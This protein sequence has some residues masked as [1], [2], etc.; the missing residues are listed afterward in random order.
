MSSRKDREQSG[1]T[2]TG[3]FLARTAVKDGRLGV[4]LHIARNLS[5]SLGEREL[6]GI[7]M[8]GLSELIGA[9]RSTLY[10]VS[11]DGKT[12]RSVV[13]EGSQ[14]IELP[15]GE[16]IAGWVAER[17]REL[18]LR[19]VYEDPRF[20]PTWDRLHG[21]RTTSML[22]Q[23]VRQSDGKIIAVAQAINKSS[24]YFTVDDQQMM[25]HIMAMAAISIVNSKL[26][27]SLTHRNLQLQQANQ[28]LDEYI[29]EIQMLFAIERDAMVRD[30]IEGVSELV[31][32]EL[33]RA[34]PC[35]V[36]QISLLHGK[37]VQCFRLSGEPDATMQRLRRP[38]VDGYLRLVLRDRAGLHPICRPQLERHD[39]L[40]AEE[41]FAFV[42]D[43]GLT[44]AM[45]T[46]DGEMLGAIGLYGRHAL[47]ACF[48]PQDQQMISLVGGNVARILQR[49]RAREQQEQQGRL[50]SLGSALSM[51]LHDFK[52]P[53]TI[54]SGYVQMMAKHPDP[55]QRERLAAAA[56]KQLDRV[57]Q[58]S[59]EVVE[60]AR[61]TRE[62]LVQKVMLAE[63]AQEAE[64]LVRQVFLDTEVV[65][66]VE[67]L[68]RGMARLDAFK[69][70]RVV[71][72]LAR[73]AREAMAAQ[74]PGRGKSHFTLRIGREGDELVFSF[75]DN[76]PG[77]PADFQARMFEAFATHGKKDGSGLGL[78]M[79]ARFAESHGG[80]VSYEDTPGGGATFHVR[81]PRQGPPTTAPTPPGAEPNGASIVAAPADA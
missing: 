44:V 32:G 64:E 51:V 10:L 30:T 47:S 5:Q 13:A 31:L 68:E 50:A 19:D 73:N 62:L 53:M 8:S 55:D 15:I 3:E 17:G 79:V 12:L 37:G 45:V 75:I 25:R 6:I 2:H 39:D 71:Q 52:T 63:F 1:L 4:V 70:L 54:A 80:G 27:F 33:Q 66:E 48:D 58:M 28:E 29:R 72:N 43:T 18:N 26:T 56:L 49:L 16:G 40:A 24:G 34:L 41:G 59:K 69:L 67:A 14:E 57:V 22:C 77:V 7:I 35:D 78:A 38:E 74:E 81:F 60:F 76:G 46:E 20:D 23:P 42:P 36:I 61:G 21:Y 11:D 65:V 9:D